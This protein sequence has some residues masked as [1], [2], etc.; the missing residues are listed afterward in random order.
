MESGQQ[1]TGVVMGARRERARAEWAA[2]A[3][4]QSARR[5][6]FGLHVEEKINVKDE[7]GRLARQASRDANG[8]FYERKKRK[9]LM[10]GR[11]PEGI[12]R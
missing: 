3:T 1:Q 10:T 12:T 2:D 4:L 6:F 9:A 8:E 7:S 5:G 11:F